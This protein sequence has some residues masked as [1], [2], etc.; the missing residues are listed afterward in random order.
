MMKCL[1][2]VF[3]YYL[4]KNPSGYEYLFPRH[5]HTHPHTHARNVT[6][7]KLEGQL[8]PTHA[9][10]E[11]RKRKCCSELRPSFH[12]FCCFSR[13]KNVLNQ[14]SKSRGAF[15]SEL[16]QPQHHSTPAKVRTR[17]TLLHSEECT[18][19]LY[20]HAANDGNGF[21]YTPRAVNFHFRK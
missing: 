5:C 9:K 14:V 17:R 13:R 8:A 19:H 6:H 12:I 16:K 20:M 18:M 15:R 1:A 3:S 2:R 21:G 10:M 11:C 7:I 4:S